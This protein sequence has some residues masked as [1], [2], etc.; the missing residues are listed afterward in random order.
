MVELPASIVV[1][2]GGSGGIGASLV[3]AFLSSGARVACLDQIREDAREV[4]NEG[5]GA[6]IFLPCDVS[7]ELEV[8]QAIQ[9]VIER[10]GQ[11]DCLV[12]SAA[13]FQPWTTLD[14]FDASAVRRLLD[15]NVVGTYNACRAALPHLRRTKGNVINVSSLA[16]EMGNWHNAAY[17]ASKAAVTAMTKSLAIDEA[18]NG[19]RANAVL[20]SNVLTPQR[21]RLVES[22]VRRA[23]LTDYLDNAQWNQRSA[24]PLEIAELCVFLASLGARYITGAAIPVSGGAELGYGRKQPPPDFWAETR[25]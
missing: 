11:I 9:Q 4:S 25:I 13:I 18:V 21:H 8:N 17:C 16:G 12:N 10:W 19:V 20:P 24:Q 1:V 2:T 22:A 23:E 5:E 6:A 15:V 14:E 3:Q 7:R